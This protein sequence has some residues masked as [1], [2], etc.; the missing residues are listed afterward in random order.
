MRL[1]SSSTYGF[2]LAL[3]RI[4][5]GGFW[6]MH[7]IPKFTQSQ[8]FMPPNGFIV[9]FLNNAVANTTGPYQQFL[10]NTVVPNISVFAELVRLGEVV[11]GCLLLLGFFT[12]LGGLIGVVLALD[13]L[14]AKGGLGHS[15]A[16]SGIDAAALALS[17]VN[18]VLPTGRFLGVDA[19]LARSRRA[20]QAPPKEQPVFVDEP[21][22][23]GP[24]APT[25]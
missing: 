14:S 7:G 16:W 5:A 8:E 10:A 9:Q 13:Y 15:T 18:L 21:P 17:A 24:S 3:L 22:M 4:Y 20:K 12:R 23:T 6:L 2:W 25:S 1:P 11:T 19:L